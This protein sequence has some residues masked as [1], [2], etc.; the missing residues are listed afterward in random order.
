MVPDEVKGFGGD[1]LDR[2]VVAGD[3]NAD[4]VVQHIDP[5]PAGQTIVDSASGRKTTP[6]LRRQ[7][8]RQTPLTKESKKSKPNP[9][10]EV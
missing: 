3:A 10:K 1:V 8:H 6:Q 5:P 4:V 2:G 7:H 9:V